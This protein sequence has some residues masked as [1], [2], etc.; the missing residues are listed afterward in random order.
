MA[1]Y[2]VCPEISA[3]QNPVQYIVWD[4]AALIC[5]HSVDGSSQWIEMASQPSLLDVTEVLQSLS[6]FDPAL[7]A[8]FIAGY[9]LFFSI[10]LTAGIVVRTMRRV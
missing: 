1:R 9:L 2:L 8:S 10:G 7:I 6:D 5:R 4:N 3:D